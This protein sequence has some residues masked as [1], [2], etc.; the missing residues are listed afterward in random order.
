ML[1]FRSYVLKA[2]FILGLLVCAIF[3]LSLW[4]PEAIAQSSRDVMNRLE[5]LE[6]EI[7]TLGRAVYKGE[8][9]PPGAFA[10]DSKTAA[11][12]EVRL[13]ELET[14]IRT[15][16][17]KVE[18]QSYEMRQMKERLD[19]AL[20]DIELRL[21]ERGAAPVSGAAGF[22]AGA[23]PLPTEPQTEFEPGAMPSDAASDPAM[24]YQ[25]SSS[26]GS[27]PDGGQLGVISGGGPAASS[28][29]VFYETAFAALK[30]GDYQKSE[31]LFQQFLRDYPKDALA[32]NAQ[33]WLGETYYARGDY[34]AAARTFAESY[35]NHPKSTKAPDNLLKLGLSL[36]SL[37]KNAD[38][39]VALGQIELQ[40]AATAGAVL[41]RSKQ[42]MDRLGC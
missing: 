13:Q 27:A 31:Q 37:G 40:Y 5:R 42:E 30:S 34:E 24:P 36:A 33:Y 8:P 6:N 19:R 3:L 10:A 25:W 16:T 20:S 15:L 38:A 17:G 21:N 39:C 11:D 28:P 29:A 32:G 23:A 1:R 9:L 4:G 7:Q 41:R 22:S 18:E 12:T 14:Q 26:G 2:R 35:Q